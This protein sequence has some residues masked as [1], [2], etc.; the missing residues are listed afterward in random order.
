M[1]DFID[2]SLTCVYS[3][4]LALTNA[5]GLLGSRLF[6]KVFF[7]NSYKVSLILSQDS[8]KH[9]IFWGLGL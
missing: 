6:L 5:L 1:S 8:N 7:I 4:Y 3:L 2:E 9:L